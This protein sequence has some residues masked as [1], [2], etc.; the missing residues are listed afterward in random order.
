MKP[1]N[2][3]NIIYI[4][5][6]EIVLDDVIFTF[7]DLNGHLVMFPAS[8]SAK[9]SVIMSWWQITVTTAELSMINSFHCYGKDNIKIQNIIIVIFKSRQYN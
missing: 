5:K 6:T 9:W 4:L 7:P 8:S 3:D 2:V 1:E